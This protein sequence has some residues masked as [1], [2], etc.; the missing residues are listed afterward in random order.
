LSYRFELRLADGDDAGNLETSEANWRVGD[1]VVAHGNKRYRVTAVVPVERIAEFV[2]APM[3]GV[4][5]V[6]P[7]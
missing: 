2:D 1:V 6:Q 4:L 7:L 3:N 5:E